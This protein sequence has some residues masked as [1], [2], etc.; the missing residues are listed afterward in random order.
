MA[1][2]QTHTNARKNKFYCYDENK[3]LV[4]NLNIILL[5][6]KIYFTINKSLDEFI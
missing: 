3:T 2:Y 5:C 4:V 1:L 6:N